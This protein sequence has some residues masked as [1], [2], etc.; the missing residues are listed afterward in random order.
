MSAPASD[1]P[2]P[3]AP[4]AS[5]G[6]DAAKDAGTPSSSTETPGNPAA[7]DQ[8]GGDDV[9][10]EESQPLEDPMDDIPAGVLSVR[11]PPYTLG[12]KHTDAVKGTDQEIRMQARM[13][14]NEI[15]MMRQEKLRLDHER[16]EMVEVSLHRLSQRSKANPNTRRSPIIQPRLSRTRFCHI[17]CRRWWR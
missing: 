10:M 13:I 3:P 5:T 2:P 9:A 6:S 12:Y 16:S 15:R 4:S 11:T 1:P 8:A 7:A 14:D 17:W